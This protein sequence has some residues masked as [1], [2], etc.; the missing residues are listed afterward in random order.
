M[1]KVMTQGLRAG[2]NVFHENKTHYEETK[3]HMP[4]KRRERIVL[5]HSIPTRKRKRGKK[6]RAEQRERTRYKEERASER[7]SER[8]EKEREV[9]ET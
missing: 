2:I 7:A 8:E 6:E 9:E 1:A 3:R 5:W 4:Q